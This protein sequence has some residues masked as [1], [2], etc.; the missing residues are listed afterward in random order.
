MRKNINYIRVSSSSQ[1]IARQEKMNGFESVVD[2]CSGS[3]PFFDRK[4]GMA[5]QEMI[6]R[7]ELESLHVNSV[8]RL[9]RNI[10]DILNTISF[11]SDNGVPIHFKSPGLV[12]LNEDG[13]ENAISKLIITIMGSL[14][15][16]ERTQIRERQREGIEIARLK[17]KYTGRK[18]G[19]KED[20]LTFLNKKKNQKVISYLK[21]GYKGSEIAQIVGVH[22]NTITK[23]KKVAQ[24]NTL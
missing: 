19:T 24:L 17:G 20:T 4:G 8:D 16:M 23:I 10:A 3:I 22:P 6:S 5:I 18:S 9:G 11:F 13:S 1:N 15:E 14:A 12:T 2:I 21:K 7:S